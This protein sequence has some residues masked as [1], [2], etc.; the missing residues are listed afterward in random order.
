MQQAVVARSEISEP[1]VSVPVLPVGPPYPADT[2]FACTAS[3][4]ASVGM[5]EVITPSK[6]DPTEPLLL[7]PPVPR[8]M[9]P[10]WCMGE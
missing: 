3:S 8:T 10:S 9:A 5:P 2:M 1:G 6:K 7:S 4:A